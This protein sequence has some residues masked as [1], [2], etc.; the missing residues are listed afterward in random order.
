MCFYTAVFSVSAVVMF[1]LELSVLGY[2]VERLS[3]LLVLNRY[4]K[5]WMRALLY[6]R[7][8]CCVTLCV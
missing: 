5:D 1:F 8:V 7:C 2:C 4:F 6:I 3:F